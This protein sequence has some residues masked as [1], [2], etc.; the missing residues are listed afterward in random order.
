MKARDAS[1]NNA[2]L[3]DATFTCRR[4]LQGR[5]RCHLG[6]NAR[7][8]H[9]GARAPPLR[10][11]PAAPRQLYRPARLQAF[12]LGCMCST[13]VKY[14]CLHVPYPT[15]LAFYW[16][17]AAHWNDRNLTLELFTARC[18]PQHERPSLGIWP[19]INTAAGRLRQ[20][21][22]SARQ[23]CRCHLSE[24]VAVQVKLPLLQCPGTGRT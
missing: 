22:L 20:L 23:L 21:L 15:T 2:S 7:A 17:V 9:P 13:W 16:P 1:D 18:Q 6:A 14:S 19:K 8:A 3:F 24:P 10:A 11:A 12:A 4:P 5:P